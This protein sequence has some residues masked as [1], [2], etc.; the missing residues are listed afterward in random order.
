MTITI[1]KIKAMPSL[2]SFINY[3]TANPA[4]LFWSFAVSHLVLWTVIPALVSPNA[5][6]DV[7]EG[8]AWGREWLMGTY[9]HPPMQAWCLETLLFLT[10]RAPWAHFLAS[11]IA[12]MAAFWAVWQMSR[13]IMA[14]NVALIGALLLEGVVYYNFTST[15]FN[16][17]VLQ[18]PFW[19][20]IGLFFH[21]AIKEDQLKDWLLLGLWSACG[22][23]TKYSTSLLLLVFAGLLV[24]HP[25]AR[26]RLSG[27]GPYM[28]VLVTF[29]LFLPH[30]VW[31]FHNDFLPIDYISSRIERSAGSQHLAH[32]LQFLMSQILVILPMMIL[33]PAVVTKK[34]FSLS[35]SDDLEPFDHH[36]LNVMVFGP[37][38]ILLFISLIG[39]K[40]RDMWGTP[41]WGYMGLWVINRPH[42]AFSKKNLRRFTYAWLTVFAVTLFG[43]AG[44]AVYYPYLT[45]TVERIHFPGRAL[46]MQIDDVW[47]REEN[48][49]LLYVIGD[50]WPS[51]NVAYY[52]PERP[53]VLI[54]G[55]YTISPWIKP[56]DIQRYG[57]VLTWC[58]EN[59]A[60]HNYAE[61]MPD[62]IRDFPQ[63]KIQNPIILP[64]QTGAKVPPVT[65][66]WAILPPQT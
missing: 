11:Q 8:Y 63:A 51:G 27:K 38:L 35:S 37:F 16:P 3:L 25:E 23:Y 64:R 30:I 42:V 60:H 52:A 22:L 58:I 43:Y 29:L 4:R 61:Q 12:V 18:L 56:E 10:G 57:A 24:L 62:Y 6:L 14:E 50:T 44:W 47:H 36:F 55:D 17:N 31:L 15:E 26:R 34:T 9:K 48:A 40:V 20:L 2:R 45:H 41:L 21:R 65:V 33:L 13:R 1:K 19:A 54:K 46:A 32:P 39:V 59:C 28:A 49:P 5:P 53:H 66:G 7:I